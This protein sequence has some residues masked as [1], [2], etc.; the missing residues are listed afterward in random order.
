MRCGVVCL[1]AAVGAAAFMAGTPTLLLLV[2]HVCPGDG[3]QEHS[4][5]L[6]LPSGSLMRASMLRQQFC[7]VVLSET[8]M[9]F[10][11]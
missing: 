5:G 9:S 3:F 1:G 11:F 8:H 7:G 6:G 4:H 2:S 10:Y